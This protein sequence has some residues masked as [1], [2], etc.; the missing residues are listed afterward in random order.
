MIHYSRRE[1]L[2]KLLKKVVPTTFARFFNVL[3]GG[4]A[5]TALVR[6]TYDIGFVSTLSSLI[7]LY[8]E[9]IGKAFGWL[10]GPLEGLLRSIFDFRI[11]L[12]PVWIHVC[13]LSAIYF[14]RNI[15]RLA[16]CGRW[17]AAAYQLVFA[18]P[19]MLLAGVGAGACYQGDGEFFSEMS[20][21]V[22]PVVGIFLMSL[23]QGIWFA[24]V[25]EDR[26]IRTWPDFKGSW[27]HFFG[28]QC[29]YGLGLLAGGLGLSFLFTFVLMLAGIKT[30]AVLVLILLVLC[31]ALYW[32]FMGV[33]MARDAPP[34]VQVKGSRFLSALF[35]IFD[36]QAARLGIAMMQ[37]LM[38]FVFFVLI[39][40]GWNLATR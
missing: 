35:N 16:G 13:T 19:I 1:A 40:V 14:L 7:D 22:F 11:V 30:P 21:P 25:P 31:L 6:D 15:V 8:D 17:A 34:T 9:A 26:E 23:I 27:S 36:T 4:I 2:W 37:V 10:A 24:S 20:V 29:L 12:N 32:L 28:M 39:D 3:V 18:V 38:V 5:I 33:A